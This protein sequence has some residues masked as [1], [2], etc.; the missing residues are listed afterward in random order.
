MQIVIPM[1]G[2]GDRFLAAGHTA[3]KPLIEVDGLPMIARVVALFPGETNFVFIC[4]QDHLDATPLR[5][6]LEAVAPTG[7]IV[8]IAPHKLGP[9]HSCLAAAEHIADDEPVLVNYCDLGLGW[10][11]AD[12]KRTLAERDP[13]GALTAY[14]GFHPHTLSPNLYATMRV[15]GDQLL[16]IKEKGS[17]TDDR[18]SEYA[19]AGAYYFRTGRLLK[20]I[21]RQAVALGLK[22][23]G[24]YYASTPYN[25]LVAEALSVL[26]YEVPYFLNWGTPE[27]LSEYLGWS[28][29]FSNPGWQP[30]PPPVSGAVLVPMAGA[31]ERFSRAGYAE[32]KPLVP[33]AG[34]PMVQRA[35]DTL[36][37]AERMIVVLQAE[38]LRHPALLP[39][40][41]GD[42]GRI[43]EVVTANGLTA[44]QASSCLLARDALDPDAPLFIGPCDAAFVYDEAAWAALTA[45]PS[46]AAAVWTFRDHA[47]ANRY[48]Q[49][50]GWVQAAADGTISGISVKVPLHAE[51]RADP[52]VTGAFWFRQARYFFE[53]ADALIAQNHRVNGEF[54]VDAVIPVLVGQGRRARLFDVRHFI[55]FGTPDAVRTYEYW[56]SY[57]RTTPPGPALLPRPVTHALSRA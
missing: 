54:Y 12:F 19:S 26:I 20:R 56:D 11:Y 18:M 8:G 15:A 33:V 37:P 55:S 38:R 24:E 6:V 2:R 29:F 27:D 44:G 28:S 31:G 13:A 14:H 41:R 39:A 48:P 42:S 52:G 51:V 40:L 25:L 36:P 16:E 34:R 57:F 46:V 10:D 23:K 32:P 4:A 45:D 47:H 3:I 35:L 49:Q 5:A 9:V 21:F 30:S 17:F 1:A 22:T 53:A 43:V 7:R 50:Y